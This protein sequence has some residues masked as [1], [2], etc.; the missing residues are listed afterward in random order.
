MRRVGD[1]LTLRTP[2]TIDLQ[3]QRFE[4]LEHRI[5]APREGGELVTPMPTDALP[6]V[7]GARDVLGHAAEPAERRERASRDAG[8]GERR[9]HDTGGAEHD[10]GDEQLLEDLLDRRECMRDLKRT[11]APGPTEMALP[12][13]ESSR[14]LESSR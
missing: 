6:Q 12:S 1:E 7:A 13:G 2:S 8:P 11:I 9:H 10:R 4:P 14:A 3:H 5:E